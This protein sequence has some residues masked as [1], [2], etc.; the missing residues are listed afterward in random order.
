[1]TAST[2]RARS[3][4]T[5]SRAARRRTESRRFDMSDPLD[6]KGHGVAA[7]EAERGEAV[8]RVARVHG[9]DECDEHAGAGGADRVAERDRAAIHV[10]AVPVPAEFAA[11]GQ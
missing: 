3:E 8:L 4:S 5:T 10:D 9:V 6:G 7:A 11:V 1:M 2:R